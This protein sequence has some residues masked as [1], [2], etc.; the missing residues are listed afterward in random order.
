MTA[1]TTK[2]LVGTYVGNGTKMHIVE[3]EIVITTRFDREQTS[4]KAHRVACGSARIT[5]GQHGITELS[6]RYEIDATAD[7][8]TQILTSRAYAGAAADKMEQVADACEKCIKAARWEAARHA[9]KGAA[10]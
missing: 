6:E 1:N 10:A 5:S 4:Y 7:F 3:A 2:V 8:I 9:E